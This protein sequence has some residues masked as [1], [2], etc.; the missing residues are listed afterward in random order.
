MRKGAEWLNRETEDGEKGGRAKKSLELNSLKQGIFRLTLRV[1]DNKMEIARAGKKNLTTSFI[2]LGSVSAGKFRF[3]PDFSRPVRKC[4][5]GKISDFPLFFVKVA[6][7]VGRE[8][9]ARIFPVAS[10]EF[11]EKRPFRTPCESPL[12]F[13]RRNPP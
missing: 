2:F 11:R 4:S 12:P 8:A 3:C 10:R 1:C 9:V 13:D 5:L 6:A 7:S